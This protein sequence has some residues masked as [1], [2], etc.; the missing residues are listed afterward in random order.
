[1]RCRGASYYLNLNIY[2]ERKDESQD[3]FEIKLKKIIIKK[4]KKIKEQF[5]STSNREESECDKA[6]NNRKKV[7][8]P[9]C[10]EGKNSHIIG[11][12]RSTGDNPIHVGQHHHIVDFEQL[13]RDEI[14]NLT[15]ITPKS[16]I[17]KI[18]KNLQYV[19]PNAKIK[20]LKNQLDFQK[21]KGMLLLSEAFILKSFYRWPKMVNDD[22]NEPLTKFMSNIGSFISGSS[23]VCDSMS[24][25]RC[26]GRKNKQHQPKFQY[27][28]CVTK[29]HKV[30]VCFKRAGKGQFFMSSSMKL[31]D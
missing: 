17:Y 23:H 3:H 20:D 18:S 25:M 4:P 6:T 19:N 2:R 21:C 29:P 28:I 1:M 10:I 7:F 16:Y 5:G 26:L 30:G 14:K 11:L 8:N 24:I 27:H 31:R 15:T 22:P 12:I 9:F 13:L